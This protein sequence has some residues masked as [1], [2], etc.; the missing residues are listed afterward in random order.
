MTS[1]RLTSF[2][3]DHI[4]AEVMAYPF[5]SEAALQLAPTILDAGFTTNIKSLAKNET[6][7][8]WRNAENYLLSHFPGFSVDEIV[9][10]RDN[11][12]FGSFSK[13]INNA[14]LTIHL[15]DYLK[16]I[17]NRCLDVHGSVVTPKVI[18]DKV[19]VSG[20][21]GK[22]SLLARRE[23]RWLSLALPPDLLL[24][25]LGNVN[26]G[27]DT[28][29]LLSPDLDHLLRDAGFGETHLHLGAA[30]DFS[31]LWV[32]LLYQLSD[33]ELKENSFNSPGAKFDDGKKFAAWLVRAGIVRYALA[34]FLVHKQPKDNFKD[35]LFTKIK[36]A[37]VRDGSV[38]AFSLFLQAIADL[39][40]GRLSTDLSLANL[41]GLYALLTKLRARKPKDLKDLSAVYELDPIVPLVSYRTRC[42]AT[43]EMTFVAGALNYLDTSLKEEKASGKEKKFDALFAKLFW[44][45]QRVRVLYYQHVTQR[46]M[47]AGLQWFIRFFG[48]LKEA[49]KPFNKRI[50]LQSAEKIC[51]G[52]HAGLRSLEVRLGFPTSNSEALKEIKQVSQCIDD[53]N[54]GKQKQSPSQSPLEVGVIYHFTKN[55]G[56]GSIEGTPKAYWISSEA[57]PNVNS[58]HPTNPTGYRFAHYFMKIRIEALSLGWLLNNFPHTIKLIRGI[59]LCTDEQGIPN[60]VLL[61]L[62]QYVKHGAKIAATIYYRDTGQHVPNFKTSVHTGEDFVHLLTGLRNIEQTIDKFSFK[63]GDR[64][65]HGIA[66][67]VDAE[68]W[69]RRSG[70]IAMAREDRLCDLVWEWGWYS[71]GNGVFDGGRQKAIEFEILTLSK[72]IYGEIISPYSLYM[73]YENLYVQTKLNYVGFPSNKPHPELEKKKESLDT[74][75]MLLLYRYLSDPNIFR[76]GR[77]VEWIDPSVEATTLVEIQKALRAKISTRNITIEVNPTSNLLIGD[78]G[79]LTSHPLWRLYPPREDVKLPPVSICIGSDDPIIFGSNLREEYQWLSDAL[80]SVELSNEEVYY[81]LNRVRARGLEVCF[82]LPY[83]KTTIEQTKTDSDFGDWLI[84]NSDLLKTL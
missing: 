5:A 41:I 19:C 14:A 29:H 17:A 70:R 71:R 1:L 13:S 11:L 12:W 60:W 18:N 55:R 48:R 68:K 34:A 32:G 62:V 28:I 10:I 49:R 67:G 79:D 69:A 20:F 80:K 38:T 51:G 72:K 50:L 37:T 83:S 39:Q 74:N 44:Q 66:L 24:A 3:F 61:P 65:G 26:Q 7:Q 15:H 78:M 8:L 47:V 42:R 81:W 45:V 36:E 46:P 33:P 22:G 76:R 9:A 63:E 23:W 2:P 58:D 59:D 21:D 64:I 35:F 16:E 6:Q 82:T 43:P 25:A 56:G 84:E 77:E 31:T 52:T 75:E 4:L 53:I 30:L 73:L 40:N 54:D 57:D 27:P